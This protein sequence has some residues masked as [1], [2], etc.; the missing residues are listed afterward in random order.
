ML[1][2]NLGMALETCNLFEWQLPAIQNE[3]RYSVSHRA[4]RALLQCGTGQA[5]ELFLGP[6]PSC[7]PTS[8]QWSL[9][10]HLDGHRATNPAKGVKQ[11]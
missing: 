2:L 3:G 5:G 7:L 10:L 11:Y 6:L 1:G 4:L 9:N 8:L